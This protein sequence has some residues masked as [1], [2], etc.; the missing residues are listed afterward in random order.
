MS[1]ESEIAAVVAELEQLMAGLDG[2]VADLRSI[3]TA[4]PEVPGDQPAPA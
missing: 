1:R 3:L 2:N 4:T